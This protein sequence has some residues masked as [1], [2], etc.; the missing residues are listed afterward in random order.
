MAFDP[1]SFGAGYGA[2]QGA[3]QRAAYDAEL[4][5]M[6][7]E[8][9]ALKARNK[10]KALQNDVQNKW[11]P[12]GV[13]L[14]ASL[15]AGRVEKNHLIAALKAGDPTSVERIAQEADKLSDVEYA[16]LTAS[17]SKELREVNDI[18]KAEAEAGRLDK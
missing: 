2:G 11:I 5:T 13:Q 14:R 18:V 17:N 1:A 12:Y 16:R 10:A 3:G 8:I 15:M 7:A 4:A 9:D 6:D